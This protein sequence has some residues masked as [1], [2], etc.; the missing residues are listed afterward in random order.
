MD[1]NL[2][3]FV[4]I[5]WPIFGAIAE[6]L[7]VKA[8]GSKVAINE[9]T[10]KKSMSFGWAFAV[11]A[12]ELVVLAVAI[13][14][15]DFR[16]NGFITFSI[17]KLFGDGMFLK[18]DGFRMIFAVV[19]VVM[20]LVATIFSKDYFEK[21]YADEIS[22]KKDGGALNFTFFSFLVLGATM[23]MVLSN[24]MFTAFVFFEMMSLCSYPWVAHFGTIKD[25]KAAKSYLIY[26]VLG[27]LVTLTGILMLQNKLGTLG[28]DE[29]A[30]LTKTMEHSQRMELFVPCVLVI[31]GFAAKAGMYPVHTWLSQSYVAA[32]APAT[33]LLS[34]VL[35]KIGII[36]MSIVCSKIMLGCYE[37]GMMILIFGLVTMIIGGLW[38]I[39]SVDMKQVVAYSSMSQIGYIIVALGALSILGEENKLAAMG[40]SLHII[41]HSVY[42][43]IFFTVI[44]MI[45][46]ECGR[47]LD[48][49]KIRGWGYNRTVIKIIFTIAV[50]GISGVPLLS[51]Y[52][53]KTFI[54]ESLVEYLELVEEGITLGGTASASFVKTLEILF[55][56][57]GGCTLAYMLKIYIPVFWCKANA[58][59]EQ[60]KKFSNVVYIMLI[61]LASF[62]VVCGVIPSKTI[63]I[64]GTKSL[65]F[66]E[67]GAFEGFEYF[68][69]EN[70]KGA[71][72][73]LAIGLC[74]YLVIAR[75]VKK[76]IAPAWFSLE[77]ILYGPI[78][79]GILPTIGTFFMRICDWSIE[80]PAYLLRKT[81][82]KD[83]S[84]EPKEHKEHI[85]LQEFMATGNLLSKSVSFGLI[86]FAA[87]FLVTMIYLLIRIM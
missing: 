54:H 58:P 48:L 67:G 4:L 10:G 64:I 79:L 59:K 28:Y 71:G 83:N 17:A 81:I 65:G 46:M 80:G 11:V 30:A 33:S 38:A 34:T 49:N 61:A 32:P 62:A 60:T 45:A 43:M 36:G 1:M 16:E 39:F 40:A 9:E 63:E 56:F 5:C 14:A 66:F 57:G 13:F 51:G 18:M 55:L 23:G 24:D 8:K 25:M 44:G 85:K 21:G 37:W 26:A 75:N 76:N 87:A 47:N 50:F 77:K 19:V 78:L 41:N 15:S 22:G 3:L 27:G 7:I 74:L 82:L 31:F 84:I 86:M 69:L 53:S 12:I 20:W 72:I 70:L 6:F 73:S 42:K 29:I 68:S 35:S 2:L 52:V